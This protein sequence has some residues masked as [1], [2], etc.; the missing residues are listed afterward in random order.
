M[1]LCLKWRKTKSYDSLNLSLDMVNIHI[2][3]FKHVVTLSWNKASCSMDKILWWPEKRELR[4]LW[5]FLLMST[6]AKNI[7]LRKLS[8]SRL[9]PN[10]S[11]TQ[12]GFLHLFVLLVL[13]WGNY[14]IWWRTRIFPCRR[15]NCLKANALVV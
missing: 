3:T 11:T 7:Q 1:Y 6:L 5:Y 12:C 14:S 2:C 4:Q 9:R 8:R 13:A 10:P 15:E